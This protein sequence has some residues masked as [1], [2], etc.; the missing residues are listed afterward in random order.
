M[1]KFCS[2]YILID[3]SGIDLL[4]DRFPIKHI[5]Y[6]DI[7]FIQIRNGYL[8]RNRFISLI[9]GLAFIAVSLKIISPTFKISSK[10]F[11]NSTNYQAFRGIAYLLIFFISLVIIGG[12]FIIQS[13]IRSKI[14]S[15]KTNDEIFDIRIKEFEKVDTFE[16]LISYLNEKVKFQIKINN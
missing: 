8:L 5:N 15:I 7:Q 13:L 10:L 16:N 9:A 4:R 1:D 12:Y 14:L 2:D 3:N 6:L 11:D